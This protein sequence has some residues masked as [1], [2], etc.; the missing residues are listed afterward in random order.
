MGEYLRKKRVA[1]GF[2]QVDVSRHF[3]YSTSQFVSNFERGLCS[4]PMNVLRELIDL[5]KLPAVDV[6]EFLVKMQREYFKKTLLKARPVL[7]KKKKI[8]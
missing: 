4:P 2:S 5:Y 1:A 7:N 8:A 6:I 3:G